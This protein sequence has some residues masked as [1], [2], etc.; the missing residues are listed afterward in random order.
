[1]N[2]GSNSVSIMLVM[3]VEERANTRGERGHTRTARG[4]TGG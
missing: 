3:S 1:M 2:G 4:Y